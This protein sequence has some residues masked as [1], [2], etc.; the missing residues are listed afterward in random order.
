MRQKGDD[1][2]ERMILHSDL[3][4]F[5]A[6]VEC[7]LNPDL[8][9]RPVAV[10]GSREERHG[11]VLAKNERAKKCGVATG[12]PIWA[13]QKKCPEIVFVEPHFSCYQ[14]YAR[15]ARELYGEYTDRVE[16]FGPDECW[17]DVT[18]SEK[19]FG[20][21]WEIAEN[22]R[23][24]MEKE[25][26]LTVS[27]GVSF[28]K[29]FAK[30]GSD[31]KKPNATTCITRQNFREKIWPLEADK[32]LFVGPSSQE[33]LRRCGICTI[34]EIAT[35]PRETL[36]SVLGKNGLTL[37]CF[38]NG[39]DDSPVSLVGQEQE[40]KSVG[41]GITSVRDMENEADVR[42]VLLSLC[43][44][45][46]SRLREA[47]LMCG[48]VQL[49]MRAGNLKWI[50]R[51]MKLPFPNR[52]VRGLFEAGME[53]YRIHN[54]G[55]WPLRSIAIRGID[56]SDGRYEQFSL[57]EAVAAVQRRETLDAVAD[58]IKKKFGKDKI[59]RAR[60]LDADGLGNLS[61]V[62]LAEMPGGRKRR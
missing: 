52:T 24:R 56:L 23:Q 7:L 48:A 41:N 10:A 13:A 12:E 36:S 31:M 43:E 46:S 60:V 30:L 37:W 38:A 11:I 21:G 39:M 49:D 25:I 44:T 45:V 40:M 59:T 35:A 27:V 1:R 47:G 16:P 26:G 19:L 20:N 51:Q 3:N 8:C 50:S 5:Y 18:G 2:V 62:G 9:H 55:G 14:K 15:M 58:R 6:S 42:T 34:G 32:L 28:N 33:K 61:E 57:E 53:L 4:N 29:V 17:L 54:G 22:L